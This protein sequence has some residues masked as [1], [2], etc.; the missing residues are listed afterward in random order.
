MVSQKKKKKKGISLIKNFTHSLIFL[1]VSIEISETF[2]V[3]P[4]ILSSMFQKN[5]N[6]D[7]I[8]SKV[9]K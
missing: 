2:W 6:I 7:L 4:D 1:I 5:T 8:A 3:Q 9:Q